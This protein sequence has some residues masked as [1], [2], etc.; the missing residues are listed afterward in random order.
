MIVR[1]EAVAA[2]EKVV[3]NGY[4]MDST[5]YMHDPDMAERTPKTLWGNWVRD[6]GCTVRLVPKERSDASMS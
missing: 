2:G 5:P 6:L 4:T 1:E 3:I